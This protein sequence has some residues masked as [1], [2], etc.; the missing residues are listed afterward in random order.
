MLKRK[1]TL[2]KSI[3]FPARSVRR[4]DILSIDYKITIKSSNK[5]I[6]LKNAAQIYTPKVYYPHWRT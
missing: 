1:N 4:E 5:Q 6:L 2:Y 3:A